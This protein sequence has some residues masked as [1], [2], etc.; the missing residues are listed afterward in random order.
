MNI[1]F[2]IILKHENLLSKFIDYAAKLIKNNTLFSPDDIYYI[3]FNKFSDLR[4][5]YK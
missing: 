1:A 2:L 4:K 5:T 3:L